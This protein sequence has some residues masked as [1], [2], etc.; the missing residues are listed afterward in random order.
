MIEI[1]RIRERKEEVLEGLLK[2][3]IDAKKEVTQI[4][5]LDREWRSQKIALQNLEAELNTISKKIGQLFS[6]GKQ[7]EA[8]KLKTKT[9]ELKTSVQSV[10]KTEE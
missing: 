9:A 3:N 6:S 10:K 7:A 1:Q 8:Q 4:L 2:R 5:T